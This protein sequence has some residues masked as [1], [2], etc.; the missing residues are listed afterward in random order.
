MPVP[1]AYFTF[2]CSSRFW[3]VVALKIHATTPCHQSVNIPASER[4]TKR[5]SVVL[6]S[7][8]RNAGN[9]FGRIFNTVE[10]Y[11]RI[12]IHKY[13]MHRHVFT[14]T[15]QYEIYFHCLVFYPTPSSLEYSNPSNIRMFS[16]YVVVHVVGCFSGL[17]LHTM[18]YRYLL[19]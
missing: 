10:I 1:F 6:K 13:E 11:I 9:W 5:D 3:N 18:M 7:T 8:Q 14:F 17:Y 12:Y 4:P 16:E 15:Y 19:V 2:R